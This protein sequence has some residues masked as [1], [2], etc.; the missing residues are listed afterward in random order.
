MDLPIPRR[1][2]EHEEDPL[3]VVLAA[4]T[5]D[6]FHPGHVNLLR[7]AAGLGSVVAAVNTDGFVERYKGR[8][9]IMTLQERLKTVSACRYVVRVLVNDGPLAPV[10]EQARPRY[11]IHGNDWDPDRYLRQIGCTAR[12][13]EERGVEVVSVPYTEGVSTTEVIRRCRDSGS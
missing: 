5:F 10:I 8:P 6:L 9:P 4:G 1:Q 2:Q 12:W 3:T 7:Q 11:L 13:L